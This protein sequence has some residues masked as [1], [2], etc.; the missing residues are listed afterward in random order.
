MTAIHRCCAF[1]LVAVTLG[2]SCVSYAQDYPTRFIRVIVGPGP[3][4]VA[5]LFG[6]KITDVAASHVSMVSQ[7]QATIETI[8]AAAAHVEA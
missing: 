4:I 7:P 3:D 5:R 6:A 8:L 2:A 1:V